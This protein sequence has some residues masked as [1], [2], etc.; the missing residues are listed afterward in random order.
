[1]D[2]NQPHATLVNELDAAATIG[3]RKKLKCRRRLHDKRQEQGTPSEPSITMVNDEPNSTT[4]HSDLHETSSDWIVECE[5]ADTAPPAQVPEVS[6]E[7]STI[8]IMPKSDEIAGVSAIF[9]RIRKQEKQLKRLRKSI[10]SVLDGTQA[11]NG[12]ASRDRLLAVLNR[13]MPSGC[14]LCSGKSYT[15]VAIQCN[16]ND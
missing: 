1:V 12:N 4:D 16:T 11:Q 13:A 7:T 15:E 10:K 14:W 3:R 5:A 8:A 6:E 2:P 9:R